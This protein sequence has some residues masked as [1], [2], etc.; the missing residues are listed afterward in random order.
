M[1]LFSKRKTELGEKF[2]FEEYCSTE[3]QSKIRNYT[4]YTPEA[5]LFA[6]RDA[7]VVENS[8]KAAKSAKTVTVVKTKV[9][10]SK[11]NVESAVTS[12]VD[13]TV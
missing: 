7:E 10:K 4:S 1:S 3:R 5:A 6:M 8:K 2:R 9:T 11:V 13:A 12:V